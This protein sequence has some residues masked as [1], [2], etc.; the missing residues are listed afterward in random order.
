MMWIAREGCAGRDEGKEIDAANNDLV[1]T[2][3]HKMTQII[4]ILL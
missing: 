2:K 1:A 4:D 3:S